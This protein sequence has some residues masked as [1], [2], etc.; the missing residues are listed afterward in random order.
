[1]LKQPERLAAAIAG[2]D[3]RIVL[4]GHNHHQALGMLGSIPVW[5]S[6]SAAYR[7]DVTSRAVFRRLP[8]AAFSQIELQG[9]TSIATVIP[10]ATAA[11][12]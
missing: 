2:S 10:I 5:V 8:G 9:S 7:A 4:C 1:M 6:P 11:R 3:V 12:L